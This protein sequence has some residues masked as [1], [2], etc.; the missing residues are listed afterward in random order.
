M[1]EPARTVSESQAPG[2]TPGCRLPG[3]QRR[4][5]CLLIGL[6]LLL[7]PLCACSV[8]PDAARS[9]LAP[10]RLSD[11]YSGGRA[12]R[13]RL[14]PSTPILLLAQSSDPA[15]ITSGALVGLTRVFPQTTAQSPAAA[16]A[17]QQ[18]G[19]SVI[20][21]LDAATVAATGQGGIALLPGQMG[22]GP[23]GDLILRVTCV[24][25]LTGQVV[26]NTRLILRRHWLDG[27]HNLEQPLADL[28]ERY[29]KGLLSG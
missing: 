18:S 4:R 24:D 20:V 2:F 3:W 27:P 19:I 13:L 1:P 23:S 22:I 21:G 14:A 28:F 17:M 12:T 11:G 26:D 6:N 15:A 7:L 8:M 10:L 9:W 29:A 5:R 16:V 25:R